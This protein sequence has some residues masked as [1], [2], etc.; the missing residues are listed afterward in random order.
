MIPFCIDSDLAVPAQTEPALARQLQQAFSGLWLQWRHYGLSDQMF[1]ASLLTQGGYPFELGFSS[2][3]HEIR[4]TADPICPLAPIEDRWRV[5]KKWFGTPPVAYD[6][7]TFI[8]CKKNRFGCWVSGRI[9]DMAFRKKMYVEISTAQKQRGLLLLPTELQHMPGNV[10]SPDLIGIDTENIAPEIYCSLRTNRRQTLHRLLQAAGVAE[11][12][13]SLWEL[14][15][16]LAQ[17][18]VRRVN[19][20]LSLGI[21]IKNTVARPVIS[22]YAFCSQLFPNDGSAYQRI[23]HMARQQQWNL[24]L[25]QQM[26]CPLRESD[27]F[28]LRHGLVGFVLQPDQPIQLTVG[29]EPIIKGRHKP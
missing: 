5:A 8:Q 28:P 10:L 4:Y 22:I 19:N 20:T 18:P 11:A 2:N 15:G 12:L 21:S 3:R 23:T 25:Y 14:L 1:S 16:E 13:P 9:S 29:I 24:S 7:D 27:C 6:L 17:L 26:A